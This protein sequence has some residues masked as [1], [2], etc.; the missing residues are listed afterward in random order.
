MPIGTLSS[1]YSGFLSPFD[2]ARLGLV[3]GD[4]PA[5]PVLARLLAGPPPFMYDWF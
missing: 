2:A 5:I 4:D 1:M 3:D